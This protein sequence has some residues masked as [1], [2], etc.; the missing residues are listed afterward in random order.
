[1]TQTTGIVEPNLRADSITR[2]GEIDLLRFIAALVVVFF[3]YAFRGHADGRYSDLPYPELAPIAKYGYLGVELFFLISG[4]VILMTASSGSLRKFTISRIVRL[5]PAYW[6]CCTLTF[7]AIMIMGNG[8][9][10]ATLGQFLVNLTMLNEFTGIASIDGVYWSLAVE[11]TFYAMVAAVLFT[12]QLGRVEWFLAA[13]LIAAAIL[14][15]YPVD[16]LRQWLITDSAPYFVGGAVCYLIHSSGVTLAR[17]ALLTAAWIIGLIHSLTPLPKLA[18]LYGSEF[19]PVVVGLIVTGCFAVML[20]VALGRT[21]GIGRRNWITVGALTYPLY[22]L[23]QYIGYM[24]LNLGYPY[25]NRHVL[26]WST[27]GAML[28]AAYA[29]NGM[30]EQRYSRVLKQ[31]LEKRLPART[32]AASNPAN[33]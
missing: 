26:F 24:M 18:R 8:R 21:F 6:A 30:I 29:V 3:H 22:L 32:P 17:G 5:Y 12:R 31:F 33:R 25:L 13:W 20:M 9:F 19:S 28:A 10:E 14:D 11:L 4:F 7:L 1:M 23:H 16:R 27:L 15:F 2:V